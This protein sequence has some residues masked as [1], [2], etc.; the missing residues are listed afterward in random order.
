MVTL[1]FPRQR[2]TDPIA[3]KHPPDTPDMTDDTAS[4]PIHIRSHGF[5]V[6]HVALAVSDTVAGAAHVEERTGVAPV[7]HDPEPGQWYRSASLAIGPDSN[8]EIIDPNPEHR[9]L[10]PRK[11]MLRGL[12]CCSGTW[13]H[14]TGHRWRRRSKAAATC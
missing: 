14:R 9:G 8:L 7:L 12:R 5:P 13:R 10:H 11:L 6:D 1:A 4:S 3:P 2:R